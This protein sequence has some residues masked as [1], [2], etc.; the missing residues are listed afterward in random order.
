MGSQHEVVTAPERA[1]R[2]T[3]RLRLLGR[4]DTSGNVGLCARA[5]HTQPLGLR[6]QLGLGKAQVNC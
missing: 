3:I 1:V 4:L 5:G 2:T 6:L